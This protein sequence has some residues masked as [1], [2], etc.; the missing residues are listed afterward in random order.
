MVPEL[1][2]VRAE[3]VHLIQHLTFPLPA[4]THE[5]CLRMV[6]INNNERFMRNIFSLND[7]VPFIPLQ[8]VISRHG[9]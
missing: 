4:K 7:A 2:R 3:E 5:K 1:C 9:A 6:L 8:T